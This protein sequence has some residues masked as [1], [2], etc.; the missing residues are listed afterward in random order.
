MSKTCDTNPAIESSE[1]EEKTANAVF[2]YDDEGLSDDEKAEIIEKFNGGQGGTP[3]NVLAKEYG[4]SIKTIWGVI[5]N[6]A[7]E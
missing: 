7:S 3:T 6:R 5:K 2:D 4:V 1:Q